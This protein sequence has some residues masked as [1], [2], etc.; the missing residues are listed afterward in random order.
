MAAPAWL[1]DT[2]RRVQAKLAAC[3]LS[4]VLGHADWESQNM[5]WREGTPL[6]VH[7][8]DSV[9]FLPEATIAG[10]AAGVFATHDEP[11]LA[12]LESSEAFLGAYESARG[13]RFS[14]YEREVAWAASIWVAIHNARDELIYDQPRLSYTRLEEQRFSRLS[15]ARV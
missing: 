14:P 13:S 11:V 12:P 3:D 10:T 1:Q 8:W 7:D 6:A 2:G 15:R 9:A 5:V 4:P